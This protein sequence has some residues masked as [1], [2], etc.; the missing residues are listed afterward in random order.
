MRQKAAIRSLFLA[1]V[2]LL[3]VSPVLAQK[4]QGEAG[5]GFMAISP[6]LTDTIA[7]FAVGAPLDNH[8]CGYFGTHYGGFCVS[9]LC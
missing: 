8:W 4:V 5:I 1:V 7:N 2:C 9:S 6:N 3:A